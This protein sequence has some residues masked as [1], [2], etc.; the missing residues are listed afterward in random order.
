MPSS[1][2]SKANTTPVPMT[3][4]QFRQAKAKGAKLVVVTAYD[5][6]MAR[7]VDAAGVDAL[8]VG[9]SLG[10]VVQGHL[11]S[12]QVTMRQM[13]YHTQMVARARPNALMIADL[14]FL[15]YHLSPR[16]A[17]RNGGRLIQA[18]AHAVKL[19]GGVTMQ[20]TIAALVRAE[21]PVM[22]H[23]GMTP[24][25]VHRFGG[26]KVQ[27][28]AEQIKADAK[29][30][31]AAGAFALVIECV[32][33]DLAREV[34][35]SVSIPT[36]GIGAGAHCDGQVLVLHDLLGLQD[37]IKPR[38]V[39]R[40]AEIGQSIRQAIQQFAQEVRSEQFPGPEQSFT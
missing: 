40:Y 15:S 13:L 30:V 26:F 25:S 10:M 5:C 21:I 24:Q 11:N 12:L 8:L 4:P 14:P 9:D 33:A 36:I 31:E 19:E 38:F 2:R 16:Q 37:E 18:G 20:K 23:V 34:T 39:K 17:I 28:N 1:S 22:G 3:I 27:R 35:Q 6:I 32:P 7:L 29:A